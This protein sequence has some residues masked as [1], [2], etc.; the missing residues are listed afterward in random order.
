M[1]NSSFSKELLEMLVKRIKKR[2]NPEIINL[3]IYLN[4]S[5]ALDK[6]STG[7]FDTTQMKRNALAN[8]ADKL[9]CHL[10]EESKED[11]NKSVEE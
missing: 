7:V 8:T 2:R 4:D 6:Q 9:F 3:L 11:E 1:Q 10:F 5:E